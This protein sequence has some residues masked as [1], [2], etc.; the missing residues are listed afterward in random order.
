MSNKDKDLRKL[1]ILCR[2]LS[3]CSEN[4]TEYSKI[5]LEFNLL[6]NKY[7]R[8]RAILSKSLGNRRRGTQHTKSQISGYRRAKQK[9]D[10]L[11]QRTSMRIKEFRV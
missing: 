2:E 6:W 3:K 8:N 10:F 11:T 4:S 5:E 9:G 1:R 7:G